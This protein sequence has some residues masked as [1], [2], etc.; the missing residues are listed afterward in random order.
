[1]EE[2]FLLVYKSIYLSSEGEG[3]E[4]SVPVT[5]HTN[6]NRAHSTTLPT[7]LQARANMYLFTREITRDFSDFFDISLAMYDHIV[8]CT[9][10]SSDESAF[11]DT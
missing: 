1:M 10:L 3:F 6:S 2:I 5:G 9:K 4:P 11:F 7:F 8:I